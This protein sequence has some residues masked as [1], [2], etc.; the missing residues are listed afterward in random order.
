MS[1]KKREGEG[2]RE[3]DGAERKV[4]NGERN[5][6]KERGRQKREKGV[7]EGGENTKREVR[8]TEFNTLH[9]HNHNNSDHSR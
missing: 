6:G 1:K 7:M 9:A 4:R 3:E 8:V 2:E 5:K